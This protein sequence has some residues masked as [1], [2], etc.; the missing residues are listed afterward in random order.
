MSVVSELVFRVCG[1]MDLGM[2]VPC[3]VRQLLKGA[4]N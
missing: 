1:Y 2:V 3:T 4:E